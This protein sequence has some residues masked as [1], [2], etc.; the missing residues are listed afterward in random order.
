MPNQ[1]D[2][3]AEPKPVYANV[4]ELTTGPYD[5]VLDFGF[6]GPESMKRGPEGG[7]EVVARVAMSLAHAKSMVPLLARVIAD[8]E[9]NVGPITAP[10]FEDLGKQ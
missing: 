5:I 3:A 7:Y 4:V 2:Q 10:G 1:N 6:R 9:E 8:Y